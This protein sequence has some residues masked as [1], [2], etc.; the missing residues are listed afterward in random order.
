MSGPTEDR[1]EIL[2]DHRRAGEA[3]DPRQNRTT[4][5]TRKQKQVILTEDG[6]RTDRGDPD[7]GRPPGRGLGEALYDAANVSVVHHRQPGP[8]RQHPVPRATRTTSSRA[9]RWS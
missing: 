8:A 6:Q 9:A 2:Q 3:A 7:V 5:T 4:T 1:S